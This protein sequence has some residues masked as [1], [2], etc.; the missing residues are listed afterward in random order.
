[1]D[2]HEQRR[3]VERA[4]AGDADAWERLY[5]AVYSRL[6]AYAAHHG[7]LGVADDLVSETMSRAVAGVGK[8]EWLSAGFDAWLV[9][10]LRRVCAE[11][12]RRNG[13][14]WRF[15]P[16]R[17]VVGERQPGE[18]LELAEDHAEVRRAFE[19]L[20]PAER[21]VLELRVIADLSA[22]DVAAVLGKTAGTVRT[23]QSRALA[24]L[25]QLM[26]QST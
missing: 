14:R 4:Q 9:G 13:H 26:D 22:E 17:P 11:H 16:L 23:A 19:R 1:M 12:H 21:E 3:L 25:R 7:G 18:D 20:K 6:R 10:I 8:F 24:H 2:T 5:R 15:S